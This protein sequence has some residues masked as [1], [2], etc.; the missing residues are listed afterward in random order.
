MNQFAVLTAFAAAL[1]LAATAL[2]TTNDISY[3]LSDDINSDA[4]PAE[5]HSLN[6]PRTQ[7]L[8][9]FDGDGFSYNEKHFV[10]PSNGERITFCSID[11][12]ICSFFF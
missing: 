9:V 3:Q 6:N 5:L 8:G 12:A 7:G 10:Q 1:L 2:P 11:I 4:A